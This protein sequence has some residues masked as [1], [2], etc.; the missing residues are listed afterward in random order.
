MSRKKTTTDENT[1]LSL[2]DLAGRLSALE[3]KN[4]DSS[5]LQHFSLT[6]PY[7]IL[8]ET[9]CQQTS[10]YRLYQIT[11]NS[12]LGQIL[13][14]KE[15]QLVQKRSM[16]THSFIEIMYVLSGQVTMYIEHQIVTY[17]MG[18][19]CVMN[20]NIRHC[21]LFE[22]EFQVVFFMLGD[23]FLDQVFRGCQEEAGHASKGAFFSK[24]NTIF[25]LIHDNQA[26]TR[27]FEKIYLTCTPL[28]SE[29]AAVE[30]VEPIF[31]QIILETSGKQTGC[32]FYIKGAFSRLFCILASPSSYMI[33]KTLAKTGRH[34][35]VFTEIAHV[36]EESHGRCTREEL[37]RKLHYTGAY[38]NRIVKMYTGKTLSE[39]GQTVFL[40]EAVGLLTNTD[41]S[42]T[43]IVAHLGLA[44]RSYFY[45]LFEKAYG[46]TPLEYKKQRN[47]RGNNL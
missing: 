31:N 44:N 24:A 23:E 15:R 37:A 16:H 17:S 34:D 46:M 33:E 36:M 26:D 2:A 4:A 7:M 47:G 14:E 41:M 38:I 5:V 45:R 28:I 6:T 29:E 3:V 8:L 27:F 13:S 11:F 19:C 42:I 30:E 1:P 10:T 40:E 32:S 39:Y 35:L 9:C 20:R 43:E 12:H 18:Q 25:Q 22:G 21:E